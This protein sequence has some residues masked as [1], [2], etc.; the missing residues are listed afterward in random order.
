M[1]G[2][3]RFHSYEFPEPPKGLNPRETFTV[4]SHIFLTP[5]A[6]LTNSAAEKCIRNQSFFSFGSQKKLS[7]FILVYSFSRHPLY[8][9]LH[10]CIYPN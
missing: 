6:N 2:M 1:L 7:E 4:I 5:A 3:N 9:F 10:I 8:E